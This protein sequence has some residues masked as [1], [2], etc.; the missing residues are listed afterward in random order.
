[1]VNG[2]AGIEVVALN[3]G[4]VYLFLLDPRSHT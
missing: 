4:T 2:L 1:M 3:V